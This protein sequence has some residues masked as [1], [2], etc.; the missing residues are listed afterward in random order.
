MEF[1]VE[2][3]WIQIGRDPLLGT[4]P[5]DEDACLV[6][7]NTAVGRLTV[8]VNFEEGVCWLQAKVGHGDQGPGLSQATR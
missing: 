2:E 1:S 6:D 3:I 4:L 5:I 8:G 7:A